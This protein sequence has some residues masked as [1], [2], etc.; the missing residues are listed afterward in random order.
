MSLVSPNLMDFMEL[1]S[2]YGMIE[3]VVPQTWVGKSIRELNIRADYNVNIVAIKENGKM[4]GNIVVNTRSGLLGKVVAK[5]TSK[6]CSNCGFV[7]SSEKLKNVPLE[8]KNINGK[9]IWF[10]NLDGKEISLDINY[11]VY[12]KKE[13]HNK[14]FNA[15]EEITRLK[16]KDTK[17]NN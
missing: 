2:E 5:Y 16:Q 4:S 15:N 13:G 14:I 3:R 11:E 6:T 9:D 1:S 12:V 7:A 8:L 17:K 10:A